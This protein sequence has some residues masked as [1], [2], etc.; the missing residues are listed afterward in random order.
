MKTLAKAYGVSWMTVGELIENKY[1]PKVSIHHIQLCAYVHRA[2]VRV[3][4]K[5]LYHNQ[6]RRQVPINETDLHFSTNVC[7]KLTFQNQ[8]RK[9]TLKVLYLECPF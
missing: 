3:K 7:L 6:K 8:L 9:Q 2:L 1:A 4:S 5:K